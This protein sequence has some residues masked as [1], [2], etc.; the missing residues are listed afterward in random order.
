MPGLHNC[1]RW[2]QGIPA[3]TPLQWMEA[4]LRSR[5]PESIS[6]RKARFF[7]PC[8]LETSRGRTSR[9]L[10]ILKIRSNVHYYTNSSL[11]SVKKKKKLLKIFYKWIAFYT[12]T[13]HYPM[14]KNFWQ[15]MRLL[16]LHGFDMIGSSAK[17]NKNVWI[18]M[19]N[20]IINL[21]F[22]F[23]FSA[24]QCFQFF[25]PVKMIND[26]PSW[27]FHCNYLTQCRDVRCHR[28]YTEMFFFLK[29]F[30]QHGDYCNVLLIYLFIYYV[31]LVLRN[32]S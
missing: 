6:T 22:F 19:W 12:I 9:I 27:W 5:R 13:I 32:A 10:K 4:N 17:K 7:F 8:H 18:K 25:M 3:H 1:S 28:K 23:I 16:V 24:F 20:F 30:I 14:H 29:R 11:W 2:S 15:L 31:L 21:M 26:V